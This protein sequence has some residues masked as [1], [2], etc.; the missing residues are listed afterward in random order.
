MPWVGLAELPA[1]GVDGQASP[2]L[3]LGQ[4]GDVVGVEARHHLLLR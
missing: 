2:D 3:D 1:V 4:A